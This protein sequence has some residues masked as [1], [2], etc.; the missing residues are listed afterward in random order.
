MDSPAGRRRIEKPLSLCLQASEQGL[1]VGDLNMAQ[2]A[3]VSLVK[4][5]KDAVRREE[6]RAKLD[7]V[8]EIVRFWL[9]MEHPSAYEEMERIRAVKETEQKPD[10]QLVADDMNGMME[11][12]LRMAGML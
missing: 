8:D 6:D 2:I 1:L 5:Y 3:A 11:Q 12:M 4:A 7:Y 10:Q 9:K